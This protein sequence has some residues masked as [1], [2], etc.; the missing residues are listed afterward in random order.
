MQKGVQPRGERP[1]CHRHSHCITKGHLFEGK[2]KVGSRFDP[3]RPRRD[4]GV[5]VVLK[6]R[7][8]LRAV[9]LGFPLT[10]R[11]PFIISFPLEVRFVPKPA[12]KYAKKFASA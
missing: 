3:Y 12:P 5:V 11:F 1:R 6:Q 4:L 9:E 10:V 8:K 7:L 2:K